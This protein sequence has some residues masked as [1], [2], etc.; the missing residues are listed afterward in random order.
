M[1]RDVQGCATLDLGLRVALED[2]RYRCPGQ[3]RRRRDLDVPV[4]SG[5][6]SDRGLVDAGPGV[7]VHLEDV[8]GLSLG[9]E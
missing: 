7:P 6:E 2:L 8:P 3:A 5:G 1:Y 9:H 4:T